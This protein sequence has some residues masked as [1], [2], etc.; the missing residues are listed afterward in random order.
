MKSIAISAILAVVLLINGCGEEKSPYEGKWISTNAKGYKGDTK[1]MTLTLLPGSKEEFKVEGFMEDK[2]PLYL[3]SNGSL[4]TRRGALWA[5]S[6]DKEH[7]S[8]N[9]NWSDS[10]REFVRADK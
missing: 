7:D 8:L 2:S 6:Y 1:I 4:S 3:Q 10:P 9:F 5:F